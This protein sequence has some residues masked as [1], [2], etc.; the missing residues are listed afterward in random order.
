MLWLA[1]SQVFIS[2]QGMR[3]AT[4]S[5]QEQLRA[6]LNL[7]RRLPPYKQQENLQELQL[8]VPSIVGE[9]LLQR[10]DV[11][12]EEGIDMKTVCAC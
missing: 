9:E 7:M 12:L 4:A 6:C 5:S 8:L 10:V 11:P 3:D 2:L 1:Q